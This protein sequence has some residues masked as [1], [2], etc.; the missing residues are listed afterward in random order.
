MGG[1]C[2]CLIGQDLQDLQDEEN[3]VNP[4]NPVKRG[5]VIRGSRLAESV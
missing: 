4:V 2:Q 1:S 3:P 5:D